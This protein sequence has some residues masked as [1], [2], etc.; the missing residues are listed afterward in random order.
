MGIKFIIVKRI[1]FGIGYFIFLKKRGGRM[2][3][4]K[5]EWMKVSGMLRRAC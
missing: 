3:F 4:M 5:G 1:I 2:G